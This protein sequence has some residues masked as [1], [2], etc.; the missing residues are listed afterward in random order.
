M[1]ALSTIFQNNKKSVLSDLMLKKVPAF[2]SKKIPVSKYMSQYIVTFSLGQKKCDF[3]VKCDFLRCDYYEFSKWSNILSN[4]KLIKFE[5]LF[6]LFL[7]W[8]N[9]L[10]CKSKEEP[11]LKYEL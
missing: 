1:K 6:N 9:F 10:V 4:W 2:F 5:N 8:E 7:I 3:V 11:L